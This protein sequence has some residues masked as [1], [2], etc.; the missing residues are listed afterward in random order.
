MERLRDGRRRY[1][2]DFK[3]AAVR[4]VL[5][6]E[7]VRDVA[8]E[9]GVP[10]RFVWRW[11]KIVLE[12][13]EDRLYEVGRAEQWTKPKQQKPPEESGKQRR[14]AE[15][16]RLVGRQQA[17]IRFLDRALRRIEELGQ[18]SNDGGEKASSKE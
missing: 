13:G 4:R 16:E 3:V 15:L 1:S 6:G 18:R 5:K 10:Y 17:E 12:R 11:K 7:L 14:I 9:L 2:R 8:A